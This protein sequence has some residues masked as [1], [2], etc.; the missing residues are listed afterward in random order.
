MKVRINITLDEELYLYAKSNNIKIS[1]IINDSLRYLI[2]CKKKNER[3][4]SENEAKELIKIAS[5]KWTSKEDW[6]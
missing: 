4:L 1:T 6:K 3:T 2:N 5:A